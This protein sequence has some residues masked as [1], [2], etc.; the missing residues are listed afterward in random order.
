MLAM[1]NDAVYIVAPGARQPSR[2]DRGTGHTGRVV[3]DMRS[4]FHE[5]F[6]REEIPPPPERSTGFVFA[7]VAVIVAAFTYDRPIV[8]TACL[9]IASALVLVSWL[10]PTLL[11]PLNLVWFRFSML[12]HRVVNPIVMMLMYVVA[13]VPTGLL[14]QIWRDPLRSKRAG[15]GT[16][17]WVEREPQNT[18]SSSMENQF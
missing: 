11:R 12:L 13:I 17:Y 14:M 3:P 8:L 2:V 9:V 18:A 6:G 4:N 15:G 7:A 16:S 10:R 5:D 1:P